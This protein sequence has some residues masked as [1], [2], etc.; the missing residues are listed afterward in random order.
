M[1]DGDRPNPPPR[2]TNPSDGPP[3]FEYAELPRLSRRRVAEILGGPI[4][5]ELAE[6]LAA[7]A[8]EHVPAA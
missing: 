3:K 1:P 8:A 5:E 7:R 6:H 4:R 2:P